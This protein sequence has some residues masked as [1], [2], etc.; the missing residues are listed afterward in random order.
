MPS[1]SEDPVLKSARREGTA[2]LLFFVLA[3]LVTLVVCYC[4]GYVRDPKAVP[5]FIL[6]FP[7]WVFWGVMLPWAAC[8]AFGAWFAYRYMKDEDL[9]READEGGA[10]DVG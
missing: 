4:T 9:G 1:P 8:V 7:A 5:R 2:A 10:D 3:L 6:G